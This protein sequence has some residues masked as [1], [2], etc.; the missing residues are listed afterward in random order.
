MLVTLYA[1]N[2]AQSVIIYGALMGIQMAVQ[3]LVSGVIW[4]EYYGRKHL[5]TIRG[6]TM[7]AGVI[8]SALGPLPFGYAYDLFGGYR[9]IIAV[10]M[11]FP[12]ISSILALVAKKPIKHTDTSHER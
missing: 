5:S 1:A 10:S 2:T 8:G 3:S 7:M 12:L 6:A 4:P 11:V 9:E